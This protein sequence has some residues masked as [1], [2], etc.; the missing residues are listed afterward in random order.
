MALV[1]GGHRRGRHLARPHRA[2]GVNFDDCN[3]QVEALEFDL[4]TSRLAAEF[5]AD[6]PAARDVV[7][8]LTDLEAEHQRH[9][10]AITALA[11]RFD[12]F[13][14]NQA[15]HEHVHLRPSES[16][17]RRVEERLY[18]PTDSSS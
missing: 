18:P 1:R 7:A 4:A 14:H 8:L 10:D 12:A 6:H 3:G 15:N 9:C 16:Y 13:V 17:R 2:C 5:W 11:A